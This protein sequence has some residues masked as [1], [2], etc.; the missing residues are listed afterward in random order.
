MKTLINNFTNAHQVEIESV[1]C[2]YLASKWH[3]GV[4]IIQSVGSMHFQ[5]DMT[6]DQ[7]RQMAAALIAYADEAEANVTQQVAA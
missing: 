3:A 1:N 5:H 2:D 6:C 4:R 7:A